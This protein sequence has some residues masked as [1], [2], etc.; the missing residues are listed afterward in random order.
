MGLMWFSLGVLLIITLWTLHVWI[1]KK[2]KKLTWFTWIGFVLSITLGFFTIAWTIS[3]LAEGEER[4][5]VMGLVLFGVTAAV[6]F[7]FTWRKM[8]N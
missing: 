6:L 5:A 1:K 7:R 4:A 3:C 2:R 8:K